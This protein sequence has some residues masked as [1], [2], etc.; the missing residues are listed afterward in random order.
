MIYFLIL[1]L[2]NYLLM[3]KNRTIKDL[4]VTQSLFNEITSLSNLNEL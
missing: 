3:N 1:T 2:F 4:V